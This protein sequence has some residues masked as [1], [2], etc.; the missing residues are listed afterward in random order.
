MFKGK[1][2]WGLVVSL[3]CL[4]LLW[5]SLRAMDWEKVLLALEQADYLYLLPALL[6]YLGGYISRAE[7][8]SQILKPTK[9]V[10][11]RR[12]LSPLIVGFMFNNI[13]PGRLGEFVFAHQ[14]GKQEGISRTTSFAAVVISR[15]LDGFTIL[16]FF[17][18]GLLAFLPLSGG[19]AAPGGTLEVAGHLFSKQEILGKVYL[20]GI[21]GMLVFGAVFLAC[22]CLIVWKDISIRVVDRMLVVFPDR[23]SR[24]G[25]QALEKFIS[26]LLIL[27]NAK[28]LLGVFLFNFVPWGMEALTYL[29][30]AWTFGLDLNIRQV[31]LVMGVTNLAMIFPSAPGGLGLFEFVGMAT[32]GLFGI[33]TAKALTFMVMVHAIILVPID[34]WGFYYLRRE[35]LSFR[36]ALSEKG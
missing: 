12:V 34:L 9:R 20:A 32:T 23:F 13:L 1:T 26:G 25:K 11:Y 14:L 16:C 30:T 27:K 18:F 31:C 8:V 36:Q 4:W 5:I 22:F 21:L 15:I 17:V 10:S 3:A 28:E 2:F 29:F 6:L 35:G 24:G 19:T 33:P 7:R